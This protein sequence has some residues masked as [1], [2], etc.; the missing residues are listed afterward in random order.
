MTNLKTTDET[1]RSPI[2][3]TELVRLATT[4][5]KLESFAKKYFWCS[6]WHL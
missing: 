4:G 1:V 3:G 6:W 5:A 2:D